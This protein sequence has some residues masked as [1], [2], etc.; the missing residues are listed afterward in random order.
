MALRIVSQDETATVQ[1]AFYGPHFDPLNPTGDK[2]TRTEGEAA[3]DPLAQ[4]VSTEA[5]R[6]DYRHV[7]GMNTVRLL[8][9][10]SNENESNDAI[11]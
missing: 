11:I 2:P 5:L 4:L 1:I 6:Y 7:L 3:A 10:I 8:I 9:S